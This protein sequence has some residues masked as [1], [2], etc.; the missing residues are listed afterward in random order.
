MLA[1]ECIYILKIY[2]HSLCEC[3]F[4]EIWGYY[5]VYTLCI[6]IWVLN[7]TRWRYD[8]Q[9]DWNIEFIFA[10]SISTI[11]IKSIKYSSQWICSCWWALCRYYSIM[12]FW[13]ILRVRHSLI[14]CNGRFV[15]FLQY[16]LNL[17]IIVHINQHITTKNMNKPSVTWHSLLI[18]VEG[19]FQPKI[20]RNYQVIMNTILYQ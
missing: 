10:K 7:F 5:A 9:E 14:I 11:L 15:F 6:K 8:L 12:S 13:N 1:L 4:V 17:N 2:V 19:W 16:M 20:T 3:W 18:C